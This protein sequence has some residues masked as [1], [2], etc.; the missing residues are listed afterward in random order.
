MRTSKTV[1]GSPGAPAAGRRISAHDELGYVYLPFSTPSNDWFGGQRP[2]DRLFGESLVC[3]DARTGKRSWYFQMVHHGLWDCDP[4]AA[5]N[6]IAPLHCVLHV[7]S[8]RLVS[9]ERPYR[10]V[11]SSYGRAS[12]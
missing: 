8:S 10:H 11:A 1:T 9:G 7:H 12:C 2:G 6:L 3:L 5:P 4:P